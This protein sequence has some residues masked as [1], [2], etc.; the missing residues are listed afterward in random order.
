MTPPQGATRS[1]YILRKVH[2]PFFW[3]TRTKDTT[4]NL[5]ERVVSLVGDA[6]LNI[7]KQPPNRVVWLLSIRSTGTS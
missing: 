4:V 5:W 1:N 7:L 2:L 6:P 3:R